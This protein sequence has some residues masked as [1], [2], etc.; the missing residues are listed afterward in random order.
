MRFSSATLL[1]LPVLAVTAQESPLE[2]V[3]VQAQ[4]WL[5][6]VSSY[7]PNPSKS[8]P[9]EVAAQVGGKTLNI[10]SLGSWENTIRSSVKP[11]STKPEEWWVLL[12][13]GNSTCFGQ[14]GKIEKAFNETAL[15]WSVNPTAP[16]MAYLN[17][18]NQPVLCNSWSAGP[19]GL[20]F[21]EVSPKPAPV[22]VRS[23]RLNTT[24]T[25]VKTF[26][27]LHSTKAWKDLAIHDGYFH[28]FD[29][30]F[31]QNGLAVP[32]GYVFWVFAIVPS[33]LFMI[34]ISFVSR[35]IMSKRMAPPG[36]PRPAAAP[37][38]AR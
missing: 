21:F 24:T 9:P 15:L 26:T 16:H 8:A 12:T 32:L 38:A 4:Y 28:P 18:D 2:Q 29:G 36:P 1:A 10:L 22:I 33:W 31:A 14:C 5:D 17:C 3:K 37:A 25:E 6:K 19:P 20:W 34:G 23:R 27:D 35:N 30:V 13:G 7:I 11:Q